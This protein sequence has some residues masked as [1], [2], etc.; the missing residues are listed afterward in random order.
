MKIQVM[1]IG[2]PSCRHLERDVQDIVKRLELDAQVEWV[3]DLEQ[4]LL[5]GLTALPGLAIDGKVIACG[6]PGKSRIEHIIKAA[7]VH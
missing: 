4:I 1:G 2:C 7:L 6:Y 5:M 3:D